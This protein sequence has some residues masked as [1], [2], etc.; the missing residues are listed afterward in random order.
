MC[1]CVSGFPL[2]PSLPSQTGVVWRGQLKVHFRTGKVGEDFFEGS[3]CV[4]LGWQACDTDREEQEG[5]QISKN[6][7]F[8]RFFFFPW[9]T[10]WNRL[11]VKNLSC[12]CIKGTGGTGKKKKKKERG[13]LKCSNENKMNTGIWRNRLMKWQKM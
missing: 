4:R 10:S 13:I 8:A 6:L 7:N 12:T 2:P 11:D 3:C 5:G 1:V 9:L